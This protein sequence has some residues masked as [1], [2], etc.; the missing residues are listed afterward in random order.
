MHRT[1]HHITLN[2]HQ[3]LQL[4][5][6]IFTLVAKSSTNQNPQLELVTQAEGINNQKKHG[7]CY[8]TNY[9]F[10]DPFS[11][12][13]RLCSELY[14]PDTDRELWDFSMQQITFAHKFLL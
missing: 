14:N 9:M 4:I 2:F 11:R 1:K 3:I 7:S 5:I 10:M 13:L 6:K 8:M 12:H